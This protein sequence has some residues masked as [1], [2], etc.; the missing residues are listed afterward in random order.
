[1]SYGV[2]L[3]WLGLIFGPINLTVVLQI[4]S[5]GNHCQMKEAF[6]LMWQ[7]VVTWKLAAS[8]LIAGS[9]G[10][11]K[12]KCLPLAVVLKSVFCVNQLIVAVI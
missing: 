9:G 8:S 3:Q 6:N 7:P 4:A 2:V 10:L 5:S 12:L 1:M 11:V